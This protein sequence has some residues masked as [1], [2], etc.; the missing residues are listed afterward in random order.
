[1]EK[2]AAI[3]HMNTHPLSLTMG[4]LK[5]I[6]VQPLMAV[7]YKQF[8]NTIDAQMQFILQFV[9]QTLLFHAGYE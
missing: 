4:E 7:E 8:D 3:V 6:P 9:Q 5:T 1:M 2:A